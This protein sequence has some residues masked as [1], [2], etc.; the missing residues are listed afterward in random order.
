MKLFVEHARHRARATLW[1]TEVNDCSRFGKVD[2]GDADS[3]TGFREKAELDG[4][5]LVNAGVYLFEREVFDELPEGDPASLERDVLPELARNGLFAVRSKEPLL[6]IGTPAAYRQAQTLLP[7]LTASAAGKRAF[8]FVDRDGTILA[9]HHHLTDPAQVHLLPGAAGALRDLRAL[10]LGIIVV[11]NQSVVGRGL[12]DEAGLARIHERMIALLADEGVVIDDI[13]HCPHKPED[14]CACRKPATLLIERAAAQWQGDPQRS[15]VIGDNIAD[16]QLGQNVGATTVLVRTG[17]GAEVVADGKTHPD[18]VVDDLRAAVPVIRRLLSERRARD[19]L[20]DAAATLQQTALSC[21]ASAV[22]AAALIAGAFA[23]GNKLLLCGNGGSAA[24]CQ[25]M[26]AEFVSRLRRDFDRP[27]LARHRADHRQLVHHG[28]RQR[29]RLRRRLRSPGRGAGP[30]GRHPSRNQHQRQ[31]GERG[32]GRAARA[33][34]Q[35]MAVVALIGNEGPL[36]ALADVTINIPS[37]DTQ[38]IQESHIAIE[39]V[40]CE[41]VERQL[42]PEDKR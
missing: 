34:K 12:V 2:V 21:S 23:A 27:G 8:A 24:D 19:L 42:Y 33:R 20:V 14:G 10:G 16:I 30:A 4:P 5:G 1:L 32:R 29:L 26:A 35:G 15:F 41:L 11:T 25:H 37:T 28:L 36:S 22:Q 17:Y 7:I 6:D 39:H 9:P 18:H 13:Y 31:L 3:V 40:I 38:H